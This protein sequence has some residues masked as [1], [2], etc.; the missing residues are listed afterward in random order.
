MPV[1]AMFSAHV[2]SGPGNHPASCT[3]GAGSFRGMELPGR[4]VKHPLPPKLAPGLTKELS[5]TCARPLGL[6]TG[7]R[8]NVSCM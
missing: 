6:L 3:M 1:V 7:Y 4:D 5:S 8:V 2:Q